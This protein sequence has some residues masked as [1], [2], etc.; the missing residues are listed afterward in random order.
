M[1][2]PIVEELHAIRREHAAKFKFDLKAIVADLA[3]H[4]D[5]S[6]FTYVE[7]PPRRA[8]TTPPAEMRVHT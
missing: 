7:L 3:R 5:A 4:R 8:E 6:R 1:R 2:D